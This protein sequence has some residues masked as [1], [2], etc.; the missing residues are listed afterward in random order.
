MQI[1]DATQAGTVVTERYGLDRYTRTDPPPQSAEDWAD[2]KARDR[3]MT[4]IPDDRL[5]K[6][7]PADNTYFAAH[8]EWYAGDNRD[9]QPSRPLFV[10]KRNART[11]GFP[12]GML[13]LSECVGLPQEATCG[14]LAASGFNDCLDL[15]LRK[16]RTLDQCFVERTSYAG[17]RA[18]DAASP[19][20]DDYICLR[21]LGYTAENGP[22]RIAARAAA[23]DNIQ[24][25]QDFGQRAPD[26]AWLGRNGGRGDPRGLC[27]PPYF[28]FQFRSD[29]HPAP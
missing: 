27:I 12:A 24:H 17:V 15:V 3:R 2:P 29:G 9:G 16:Q 1:G 21:P 10:N 25:E 13:R 11:G 8:Q 7:P 14:L 20:R 18:C 28:V 22:E 23:V 4:L 6:N 26:A 19:C 5:P